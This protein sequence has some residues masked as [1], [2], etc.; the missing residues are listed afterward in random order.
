MRQTSKNVSPMSNEGR[1]L[2]VITHITESLLELLKDKP[3]NDISISELCSHAQVGR[4]T[5]Y[6]NFEVKEDVLNVYIH[7]LFSEWIDTYESNPPKT[8]SQMVRELFLH[9]EKYRDFYG[10]LSERG[11]IYLLKNVLLEIYLSCEKS[12]LS[13]FL[14]DDFIAQRVGKLDGFDVAQG[15]PLE[16]IGQVGNAVRPAVFVPQ[17][18]DHLLHGHALTDDVRLDLVSQIG[19]H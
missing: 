10:L 12:S 18:I 11:L 16:L 3:L 2:Y 13:S 8:I 19:F 15:F 4:A 6:R 14:P 5:F 17:Q 9:L 1:N 7:K